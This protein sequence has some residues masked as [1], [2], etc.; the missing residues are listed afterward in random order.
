MV[1]YQAALVFLTAFIAAVLATPY[2]RGRS[3]ALQIVATPRSDRWH[4][5]A[6]A[7]LGGL[8][9]WTGAIV[10]LAPVFT[11]LDSHTFLVVA[12]GS[13]MMLVGLFDD[14]VPLK[15]STKLTAQIAVA[16]LVVAIGGSRVWTG[17]ALL[18]ALLSIAWIIAI[19]NAF[20][21]IDNMDGLC[22]SVAAVCALAIGFS[23]SFA[24]S[25]IALLA[26]ALA[27]AC[28]GF[29]VYN[30]PPASIFMGDS[31]SL[32]IG[33]TLAVMT[34]GPAQRVNHQLVA[35]VAA[36][37]LIMLIPVIDVIFVTASRTLSARSAMAGGRDHTSHRLVALGL[38]ERHTVLVLSGLAAVSG[39]SA[40]A[41]AHGWY[42]EGELLLLSVFIGVVL[43]TAHV[44][45][46]RV[47]GS[48][49]YQLLRGRKFTPLLVEL[50]YKRRVLEVLLDCILIVGAYYAAYRIRFDAQL[51]DY[52][53]LFV[54]SV[55]I[56]LACHSISFFVAGA[57]RSVWKYVSIADLIVYARAVT[58]GLVTSA[59]ALLYAYRFD[60][61]SRAV[62]VINAMVLFLLVTGSRLSFRLVHSLL[63]RQRPGALRA[64]IYGAG[65]GGV[66]L[67]RELRANAAYPYRA[68]A[69]LDDDPDKQGMSV[70][71]L[72]VVGGVD[73]LDA[74]ADRMQIDLVILSTGK[75]DPLR[76]QM[77]R[78]RCAE[79]GSAV[80]Q[81]EFRLQPIDGPAE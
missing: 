71:G 28:A 52:Y 72:K 56:V 8:A 18:D 49:D 70:D 23:A 78:Q 48:E 40:V 63:S 65:A 35:A 30:F 6:V 61:Y 58:L 2:L 5:G 59:L 44:A 79:R 37:A 14:V 17:S 9:I 33:T 22:A 68:L 15:P 73:E 25:G 74:V 54:Q 19:A 81:F 45:R 47:Y 57:Y 42:L 13:I 76:L 46:V 10:A 39:M 60:G 31:G 50:T 66:L 36:P 24:P 7:L 69:F 27:G 12:A 16:C 3:H 80:L 26:A 34:L 29:L 53:G 1:T 20:N 62:F 21:L 64:L 75:I 4:R 51:P 55:P 77:V 43:L 41:L 32:F 11:A 67:V 38:S